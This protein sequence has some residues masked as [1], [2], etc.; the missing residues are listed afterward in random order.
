MQ[1]ISKEKSKGKLYLRGGIKTRTRPMPPRSAFS[2]REESMIAKVIKYYKQRNLD[3][4]YQGIFENRY[5]KEFCKMMGGGYADAV[6][7]GTTAIYIGLAALNLPKRSEILVSSITD[8]GTISAIILQNLVPKLVDSKKNSFNIG[9][10]Q[11]KNRASKNTSCIIVVHALGQA[12]EIDKIVS[13]AKSRNI[14]VLEDCSQAHGA[15]LKKNKKV[16]TYGDISAFSTMYRKAS[17]SGATGGIIYSKNLSLLRLATAHADR[18]KERWK[19]NFDDR[20]PEQYI[21]PALNFHTDEI[22]CAIGISSL[23]RLNLTISKRLSY[24]YQVSKQLKQKSKTCTPYEYTKNDSPFVYPIIV[25]IK[26]LKTNK[27]NFAKAVSAEGI[28][29]NPHYRYLVSDWPWVK[30]YLKDN[31]NPINAREIRDKTFNLYLNENYKTQEVKDTVN[32]I[33][34]V[35]KVFLNS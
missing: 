25:D 28:G 13:F 31:F 22:S 7:T 34:K 12:A 2:K 15:K 24:V 32:A 18:G 35:E 4:G 14:K 27:I 6:A 11:I 19:K 3:P 26:K 1:K 5:C 30:K 29:L 10:D 20:N 21:F 23:K 33:L 16:G 9:L 8:P 17:I